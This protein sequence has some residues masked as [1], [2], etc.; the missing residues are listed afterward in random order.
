M[1]RSGGSDERWS[2]RLQDGETGRSQRR[3]GDRAK[4]AGAKLHL[5]LNKNKRKIH[6]ENKQ[7]I[8]TNESSINN[9]PAGAC[10]RVRLCS[11]DYCR[12]KCWPHYCLSAVGKKLQVGARVS[13]TWRF[14][15]GANTWHGVVEK[16]INPTTVLI[17]YFNEGL[18]PSPP[19]DPTVKILRVGFFQGQVRVETAQQN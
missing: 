5:N 8:R 11:G 15:S 3:S 7:I 2:S 6:L 16:R 18:F 19:V 1:R 10:C 14:T 12:R 17:N 9:F 4:L 13:V